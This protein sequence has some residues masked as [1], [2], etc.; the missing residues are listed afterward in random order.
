MRLYINAILDQISYETDR[1]PYDIIELA[2]NNKQI[3]LSSFEK[4][5]LKKFPFCYNNRRLRPKKSKCRIDN[6]TLNMT[7]V[8]LVKVHLL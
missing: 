7:C 8:G 5:L 1:V 3:L 6:M 4:F 2:K